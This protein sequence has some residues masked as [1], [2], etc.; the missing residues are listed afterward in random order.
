MNDFLSANV[1]FRS[2]TDREHCVCSL[3]GPDHNEEPTLEGE[4]KRLTA[5]VS[6]AI[7]HGEL[8]LA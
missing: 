6:K 4:N 7:R 3:L 8:L 1:G 5:T 2:G